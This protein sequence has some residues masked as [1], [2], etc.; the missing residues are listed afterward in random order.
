MLVKRIDH[1][2]VVRMFKKRDHDNVPLIRSYLMSVQH[3]NVEAVNDAYNDLLIEEEDYGTLRASIDAYDNFDAIELASRLERHE[4]LEFRRLAAHL[5][6]KNGRF[7]DSIALSKSDALFRDAIETAAHSD[8]A[9]V[10]ED[11]LSYFVDTGNKECYAAM[12]YACYDL[13]APDVVMEVS[14]RHALSDYTMPYQIQ[15]TC[16]MRCRLRALEKE[17]R[18]RAAKDT[19]KEKQ[20][21]EAP[22]LGPGAFGNRL[23]TSGAGAGTDMMAPQ[24]TSL[25]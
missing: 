3:L 9:E 2:R 23:L 7:E 12:L 17:V 6:R 4:L 8:V 19:A 18:E 21:E 15:H 22:I 14:W 20:E 25:F 1:G 24:S 5:Y 10:A 16:D 11:L 13:L